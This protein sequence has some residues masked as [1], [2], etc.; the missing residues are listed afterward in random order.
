M[1]QKILGVSL[2]GISFFIPIASDAHQSRIK[3]SSAAR[4]E[5]MRLNPCPANG[6][7]RGP[8]HGYIVDHIYALA[9]GGADR[10]DNMQWQTIDEAR[11][12][13]K[14][15]RKSCAAQSPLHGAK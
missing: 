10:P 11:E 8:C 12:K 1:L 15:E 9:C 5:F 4:A 7:K 2:I 13:D 3:R 14:W 6:K